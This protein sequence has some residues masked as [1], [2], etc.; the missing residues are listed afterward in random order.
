M[1]E[2][3]SGGPEVLSLPEEK[4]GP[5]K[6]IVWIIDDNLSYA[7]SALSAGKTY[8]KEFSLI[9]FPTGEEAEDRFR[10]LIEQHDRLPDVILMDYQLDSGAKN[11]KYR[12]GEEVI[13]A[14]QKLAQESNLALPEIIGISGDD[15]FSKKLL[16]AGVVKTVDKLEMLELFKELAGQ[17]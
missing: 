7:R 12:T 10:G 8:E 16:E 3:E 15:K 1:S 11:P 14:L 17:K 6:K 2:R 9:H 4:E 13:R 5:V